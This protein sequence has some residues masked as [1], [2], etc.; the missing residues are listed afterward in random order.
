MGEFPPWVPSAPTRVRSVESIPTGRGLCSG[1]R[2]RQIFWPGHRGRRG[3]PGGA[4]LLAV[5]AEMAQRH[6]APLCAVTVGPDGTGQDSACRLPGF[7]LRDGAQCGEVSCP[8][9]LASKHHE[10]EASQ[11]AQ[12]ADG[13]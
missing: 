5:A 2:Q 12:D 7:L 11:G 4:N 1:C 9:G 3:R 13:G 8:S 10:D 6:G